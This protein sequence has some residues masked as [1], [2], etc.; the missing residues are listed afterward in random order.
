MTAEN[1]VGARCGAGERDGAYQF[2]TLAAGKVI[3][4][5]LWRGAYVV[6]RWTPAEGSQG[7]LYYGFFANN[8][9]AT[10]GFDA[11]TSS[12]AGSPIAKVADGP[13]WIEW[14]SEEVT[15]PFDMPFLRIQPS[16]G[17]GRAL[18]RCSDDGRS[19]GG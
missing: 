6:L 9:D 1:V 8:A 12:D 16:A 3:D 17:S 5:T 10:T 13:D 18:V 7:L 15:V 2:P 14:G 11:T 19:D 4:L